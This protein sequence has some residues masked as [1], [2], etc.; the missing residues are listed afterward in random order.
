MADALAA[1]LTE[2]VDLPPEV[3]PARFAA[4]SPAAP[5]WH[6]VDIARREAL[7]RIRP[8]EH[9]VD[10]TVGNGGDTQ[11]LADAVGPRGRVSGFDV[12]PEAIAIA[13]RRLAASEAGAVVEF[14]C[15]DHARLGEFVPGPIGAAVANLGHLPGS[16]SPVI[17][18]PEST[19]KAFAAALDR[20]RVSGALVAVIYVG[21]DGGRGEY[22]AIEAWAAALPSE[23]WQVAWHFHPRRPRDAPVVLVVERRPAPAQDG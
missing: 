6:A 7:L 15:T 10:L 16:A 14:H 5:H 23:R 8:G 20:L 22:A 19:L 4:P 13:R 18:R 21:H 11:W 12:Q 3:A 1:H 17:T 2:G 9:V